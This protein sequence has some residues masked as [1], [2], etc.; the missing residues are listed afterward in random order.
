MEIIVTISGNLPPAPNDSITE[1][2]MLLPR[3]TDSPL[4]SVILEESLPP[5]FLSPYE[6]SHVYNCIR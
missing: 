1:T 2:E 3:R 6:S 4:P 5:Q